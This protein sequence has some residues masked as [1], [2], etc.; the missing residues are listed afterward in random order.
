M[1]YIPRLLI[2]FSLNMSLE[3]LIFFPSFLRITKYIG[4]FIVKYKLTKSDG[5]KC[6]VFNV[7]EAE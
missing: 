6:I 3:I 7:E 1:D 2:M 5:P 4:K